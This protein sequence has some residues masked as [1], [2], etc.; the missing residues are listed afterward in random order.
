MDAEL[1]HPFTLSLGGQTFFSNDAQTTEI[2]TDFSYDWPDSSLSWSV[3]AEVPVSLKVYPPVSSLEIGDQAVATTFEITDAN[4]R[5]DPMFTYQ[6]IRVDGM[7]ET[8]ISS[9]TNATYTPVAADTGKKLKVRVT[10][11]DDDSFSEGPLISAESVLI[12][13]PVT[14]TG[15]PGDGEVLTADTMDIA[16]L[17]G[18]TSVSYAYQ[19]LQG[20][21]ADLVQIA[22]A[23]SSTYTMVMADLG[24]PISVRVSFTDDM[25]EEELTSAAIS[26]VA[27]SPAT[28]RPRIATVTSPRLGS[29]FQAGLV[30]IMDAN[31][32]TGVTYTYQW[33]RVDGM[34]ETD[35][36]GATSVTYTAVAADVGKQLKVT[37]SFIDNDGF[38]ESLTSLASVTVANTPA[39]GAPTITGITQVGHALTA[40][41]T[42]IADEN[43]KPTGAQNFTDQW[44]DGSTDI[45]GATAPHYY[46]TN[47]DV[48]KRLRVKVS[49]TD[50]VGFDEELTSGLAIPITANASVKVPWSATM[51]VGQS[52]SSP[53]GFSMLAVPSYGSISP[54]TFS[55]QG[56]Q[57]TNGC[58]FYSGSTLT[59]C[60][61]PAFPTGF[62]LLHGGAAALD[63]GDALVTPI[64]GVTTTYKWSAS[65]PGW[66]AGDRV[67]V[68]LQVTNNPATGTPTISGT[69]T[70][71]ETLTADA[72]AITDANGPASPTFNYQWIRVTG[73]SENSIPVATS[74]TYTLLPA[75]GNNTIRVRVSFTDDADFAESRTS[76]ATGTIVA[77]GPPPDPFP[78][79]GRPIITGSLAIDVTLTANTSGITDQN[80]LDNV[81]YSY[82]W[83][84]VDGASES[85]IPGA[86]GRNC[87][88][89]QADVAR[90][91][92]V[93]VTFQDDDG[94]DEGPLTSLATGT[95]QGPA[96]PAPREFWAYQ[97]TPV[98]GFQDRHGA[99]NGI[100]VGSRSEPEVHEYRVE[101]REVE[102]GDTGNWTQ[103]RTG[104]FGH[105]PINSS[106]DF[107]GAVAT[108]LDCEML[109]DLQVSARS[110][111]D[112]HPY[113]NQFGVP[114]ILE[115]VRPGPCPH[116]T[117]VTNLRT[118][119]YRDCSAEYRTAG[120]H[121]AYFL[122]TLPRD[123][124]HFAISTPMVWY[125]AQDRPQTPRN[126]RFTRTATQSR[127]SMSWEPAPSHH[128]TMEKALRGEITSGSVSVEPLWTD[129]R[130]ERA[131]VNANGTLVH[132]D[133]VLWKNMQ[134][135]DSTFYT[136]NENVSNRTYVYRVR[137]INSLGESTG[138][139]GD[140]EYQ[141][142]LWIN[143]TARQT[144]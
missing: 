40:V 28:G 61:D 15:T 114:K 22:S 107:R 76:A 128:L 83:I 102:D 64:A 105:L 63:S 126:L 59:Y 56:S 71:G 113:S 37:V 89:T 2:G 70:E 120:S 130:V 86:T 144:V 132:E 7:D 94:F 51:T 36:D 26:T 65:T 77:L 44:M 142:W 135:S 116:E 100:A 60:L 49:F 138:N 117:K 24:K 5:T 45:A 41:T 115:D 32:L 12:N 4:G 8:D 35:I 85:D 110:G 101:Y 99:Q 52:G 66:T 136:D 98:S 43:G 50:N 88:L 17:N 42:G 111:G 103:I 47:G 90:T 108:G 72:S 53:L 39:T 119:R 121:H 73:N 46:P 1:S 18:L 11:T 112:G 81:S 55:F 91:I 75:D 68:A 84:R 38:S 129:Y 140:P 104:D 3:G 25:F 82:Q 29:Y 131:R 95:V 78:A 19:W 97:F 31:G 54:S 133:G 137:T 87:R 57:Y 33:V 14:I 69:E 20:S 141:N 118:S 21:G 80:G 125:E 6:W 67:A 143:Q 74:S 16:D 48:G 13:S 123:E 106:D 10:F 23:T 92:K 30:N 96:P 93:R 139:E 62:T 124:D 58:M 9:E 79:R 122:I 34:D 27:N 109:Y 127:R 134:E